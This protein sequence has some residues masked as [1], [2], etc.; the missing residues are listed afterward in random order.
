MSDNYISFV[1]SATKYGKQDPTAFVPED[2]VKELLTP[3][4]F[5]IDIISTIIQRIKPV[6]TLMNEQLPQIE[7]GPILSLST[8]YQKISGLSDILTA[9]ANEMDKNLSENLQCSEFII[10][11]FNH[12]GQFS[13]Y[14][15]HLTSST[16]STMASYIP[17]LQQSLQLVIET[18][19]KVLE[20]FP[21]CQ[22]ENKPK[23]DAVAAN[24]EKYA[25]W[26]AACNHL[27]GDVIVDLSFIAAYEA[28]QN[29]CLSDVQNWI[30]T[31][32]ECATALVQAEQFDSCFNE[33]KSITTQVPSIISIYSFANSNIHDEKTMETA[34]A[35]LI[36]YLSFVFDK[37]SEPISLDII[38]NLKEVP[39][40]LSQENAAANKEKLI[41]I[42]KK[43]LQHFHQYANADYNLRRNEAVA[44]LNEIQRIIDDASNDNVQIAQA[45]IRA[46]RCVGAA[47]LSASA[48]TAIYDAADSTLL[49]I[50]NLYLA[51]LKAHSESVVDAFT[52]KLEIFN[53]TVLGEV[54]YHTTSIIGA[55]A[56]DAKDEN[57]LK[58]IIRVYTSSICLPESTR[59]LSSV[60]DD[61][62]KGKFEDICTNI[63]ND[64]ASFSVW[65]DQLLSCL[66]ASV[67]SN[68]HAGIS[69]LVHTYQN[70]TLPE[71]DRQKLLSDIR[72]L[73][74]KLNETP[75]Y[76]A[77]NVEESADLS[78]KFPQ[79]SS[80]VKP[81]DALCKCVFDTINANTS[82]MAAQISAALKPLDANEYS[83]FS[84]ATC[85]RSLP[86]SRDAATAENILTVFP[87]LYSQVTALNSILAHSPPE[88]EELKQFPSS[89]KT[90]LGVIWPLIVS[91]EKD[92]T[93]QQT[94]QNYVT[95]LS[96]LLTEFESVMD[97]IAP[98]FIEVDI[99]EE[100]RIF[101]ALESSITSLGSAS[102][103]IFATSLLEQF[104]DMKTPEVMKYLSKWFELAN[105]QTDDLQSLVNALLNLQPNASMQDI[106]NALAHC[107]VAATKLLEQLSG[108][109]YNYMNKKLQEINAILRRYFENPSDDLLALLKA[110]YANLATFLNNANIAENKKEEVFY[111]ITFECSSQL[112][113][114]R[115]G[116]GNKV[117]A[118]KSL[119][120]FESYAF[121]NDQDLYNEYKAIIEQ[122]LEEIAHGNLSK[123]NDLI[124]KLA[125]LLRKLCPDRYQELSSLTDA[126]ELCDAIYERS[127]VFRELYN[128]ILRIAKQRDVPQPV[129]NNIVAR[130]STLA[131]EI[132]I[133]T[134]TSL[135]LT[136]L[137]NTQVIKSFCIAVNEVF[138]AL[139]KFQAKAYTISTCNEDMTQELR[140]LSR[141][142]AKRIDGFI[143][144]V[145]TPPHHDALTGFDGQ[146]AEF[147]KVLSETTVQLSHVAA[148]IDAAPAD[149][150]IEPERDGLVKI[151]T[152][153]QGALKAAYDTILS[154]AVGPEV[155][156]FTETFNKYNQQL[157]DIQ[158]LLVSSKYADSRLKANDEYEAAPVVIQ[159][160]NLLQDHI[161]I[162]PDPESADKIP[163]DFVVPPMPAE[164]P[165]A[166]D[167]F[168]LLQNEANTFNSELQKFQETI[169]NGS[170]SQ[171]V[172]ATI[173]LHNQAD[174]FAAACATMAVA[175]IE[176]RM[177]VELQTTIHSF[178]NAINQIQ[179]GARSKLLVAPTA[180]NELTEGQTQLDSAIKQLLS[181]GDQSSKY[182]PQTAEDEEA[183]DEVTAELKATA[184]AI[185][186]M[187][188]RLAE[189]GAKFG[190]SGKEATVNYDEDDEEEDSG[191]PTTASEPTELID[192]K[193]FPSYVISQA[194]PILR[195]AGNIL[196]RATEIT[197]DLVAQYGH[198][199]NE[200]ML[201][202]LA[203]EL[204]DDAGLILICAEML[205]K[206]DAGEDPEFKVIAAAKI[207]KA[208]VAQLVAQV[209]VQGGDP[210][211][212]MSQNVKIVRICSNHIV[213]TSEA[214]VKNRVDE[215]EAKKPKRPGN[216]MVQKLNAQT[217]VNEKRKEL[218]DNEQTLYRFR[219]QISPKPKK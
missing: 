93:S 143:N 82:T 119:L 126:D 127:E 187:S 170:N 106:I 39:S 169:Q 12:L 219:K 176:P 50:L 83:A 98:P 70:Q 75:I 60:C 150:V 184:A 22:E 8:D 64:S 43:Q 56:F 138:S 155:P 73:Y 214:I 88:H 156:D 197:R 94:L 26:K 51:N 71:E 45:A 63:E 112:N 89:I 180:Q 42:T 105:Q 218:Q 103:R 24:D 4:G 195:A 40:L 23:V 107:S 99:P 207:V 171:V 2:K 172:N 206:E 123:V 96:Q 164:A 6:V 54:N 58:N 86:L 48:S 212:I 3:T 118:L 163:D 84:K 125:E 202:S 79:Y 13:Q 120:N 148:R 132:A 122:I 121:F 81:D 66:C 154:I 92:E 69:T 85:S 165:A 30:K 32:Q 168:K 167:A 166:P 41:D 65:Y 210:E 15:P 27:S 74:A 160:L 185:E 102:L 193:D 53:E 140:R 59:K 157:T 124:K 1:T 190:D 68:I 91:S 5:Y 144:Y 141:T 211:G 62:T 78:D 142:M 111:L 188:Q 114:L 162:K 151:I 10:E 133:I 21:K 17:S 77:S 34:T 31:I 204:S 215:A 191:Q 19:D 145:E 174:K 37:V 95:S 46:T 18:L 101:R 175:T 110:H 152:E 196:R 205:I 67:Q 217:V 80:L 87:S 9:V 198:L 161:I 20:L 189:F 14:V 97:S 181:I 109:E 11:A 216:K 183:N 147:I 182:Q 159:T 55:N 146:K 72:G 130:M 186:E 104:A 194:Q 61:E 131:F 76:L 7:Q 137:T 115:N 199:T 201:I 29:E 128:Y 179:S 100:L 36:N 57:C 177:Q 129:I 209:L 116:N 90:S 208:T 117:D 25:Q 158:S 149:E 108:K 173:S 203:Q 178:A 28:I 33:F 136:N 52:A 35:N 192:L 134:A 16:A 113:D 135:T 139:A 47:L 49:T 38:E 200:R 213:R 153:K 44:E